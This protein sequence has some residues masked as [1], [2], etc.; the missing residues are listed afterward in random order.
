MYVSGLPSTSPCFYPSVFLCWH[1][2]FRPSSGSNSVEKVHTSLNS[3]ERQHILARDWMKSVTH[4][5]C[6]D[7]VSGWIVVWIVANTE[8]VLSQLLIWAAM[9]VLVDV[10]T[11]WGVWCFIILKY[12]MFELT[13]WMWKHLRERLQT[14]VENSNCSECCCYEWMLLLVCPS[15]QHD[16]QDIFV[17]KV[18]WTCFENF[19]RLFDWT[20]TLYTYWFFV[21]LC[22]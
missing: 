9:P 6:D 4:L 15:G 2:L 13:R 3:S 17:T 14:S 20:I 18:H 12:I 5:S 8:I 10:W 7:S 16:V 11:M 21:C 19:S 22:V 1:P